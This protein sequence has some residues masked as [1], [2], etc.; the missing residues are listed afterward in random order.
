M[1][2]FF[3]TCLLATS[4]VAATFVLAAEVPAAD[5]QP[6]Q[7]EYEAH[8]RNLAASATRSLSQD[9]GSNSWR[10]HSVV[11]LELMGTTVVS[12]E[13]TSSFG[14]QDGAPVSHDYSFTQKG[15]GSRE[16]SLDFADDGSQ[17]SF[18]VNEDTGVH[19][20]TAPAF[21][22]LNSLLVLRKQ[23]ALG[24]TDISF[25]V[26]D[27]GELEVQHYQVVGEESLATPAGTFATVHL[28]RIREAGNARTTDIWLAPAHDH[29]LVKLL[30]SEPDGDTISLEL[31]NG[32][33]G[34]H[35]I[36]GAPV[37]AAVH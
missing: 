28:Q 37:Q 23:L 4:V 36:G 33:L 6:F 18:A 22:N 30:Q 25:T 3:S 34:G 10:L 7:L 12:I 14:W 17:V 20:L 2:Q 31:L 27:R 21:D 13:E 5:P 26:A 9:A 15:L 32:T 29:V 11:E 8:Y 24:T 1:H 16:R 35:A 19:A